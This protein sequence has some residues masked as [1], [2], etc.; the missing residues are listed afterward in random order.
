M[1][2]HFIAYYDKEGQKKKRIPVEIRF[3]NIQLWIIEY[4]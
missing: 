1:I 3:G 4:Q 2:L